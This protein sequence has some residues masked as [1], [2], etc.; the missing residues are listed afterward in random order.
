MARE[1]SGTELQLEVSMKRRDFLTRAGAGAALA[2][3]AAPAIAQGQSPQVRWR[4][5]TMWPKSL[6]AMHGSAE[7]WAKRV[8]ALTEGRFEI[9][10]SAAGEIVPPGSVFDA[11]K[12]GTIECGH[13][14]SSFAFGKNPAIAFDA[15]MPFGLNTR[16]QYAWMFDG[17]GLQLMRD[18]FKQYNIV[19][20]PVGNVGVQMGGWYRK[21]IKSVADL[22]GLK[23]RIGGIG[24]AILNKLGAVPQQIPPSDVYT[25]LE[26]G[27]IDAAEWIGPYDDEKLGLYKVA[28]YY[29]TPGWW[30]GSAQVTLLINQKAWDSLPKV[31]QDVVEC[32][33]NEQ[34]LLMIAKYDAKNPEALKRLVAGGA[35]LRQFPRAVLDACYKATQEF[36]D[37]QSAKSAEFKKIYEAWSKFRDDENQWF[38]VAEHSLDSYRYGIRAS[39]GAAA[40]K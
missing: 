14:L 2:A 1:S 6:D 34:S 17:G 16:Q 37:E 9:R 3:T 32:A 29:Y 20:F 22:R 7:N 26:K 18:V 31:Y 19:Q 40:K 33:A 24:G 28:K 35:Q 27:T 21:E 25:A 23:F 5:A 36:F 30:E 15:G 13:V 38:R 4:F 12:D 10:T 8:T 39:S 11:V